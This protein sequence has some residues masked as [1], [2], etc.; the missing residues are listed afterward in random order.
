M[1][2]ELLPRAFRV[3]VLAYFSDPIATA[4][5][6]TMEQTAQALGVQLDIRNIPT[7]EDLRGAIDTRGK[8]SC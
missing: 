5:V 4:Q 8:G 3:F 6:K 1:I 2:K 7:A